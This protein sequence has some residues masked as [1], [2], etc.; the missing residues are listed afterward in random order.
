MG[1][2]AQDCSCLQMWHHGYA[3]VHDS[4]VQYEKWLLKATALLTTSK[5]KPLEVRML[6]V[7]GVHVDTWV[8]FVI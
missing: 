7:S 3:I 1:S 5:Q 2:T 8:I 4:H 6:R